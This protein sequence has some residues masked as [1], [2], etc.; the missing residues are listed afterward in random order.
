MD[1][2][3]FIRVDGV[4]GEHVPVDGNYLFD[5]DF[6][7]EL[8]RLAD[9]HVAD[10]AA[11][12]TEEVVLVDREEG[13]VDGAFGGEGVENFLADEGV[14]SEVNTFAVVVEQVADVAQV[15]VGVAGDLGVRGGGGADSQ[16]R[17]EFAPVFFGT[18]DT[19]FGDAP[20]A[21][22][23][24]D[25]LRS[26]KA[27]LR[28]SGCERGDG[29]WVAVVDVLVGK[30]Y[31]VGVAD[32]LRRKWDGN[33]PSEV[34]GVEFLDGVGEVGVEVEGGARETEPAAGLAE[35]PH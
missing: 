5:A 32:R 33:E 18:Q 29:V 6:F 31:P 21:E 22:D 34:G 8:E 23:L 2:A 7:G 1:E 19:F 20:A 14:A 35:K 4:G 28:G 25:R 3:N 26:E 10:D 15:A 30:Q 27:G 9:G 17:G 12:A 16:A 11:A 13:G 24:N